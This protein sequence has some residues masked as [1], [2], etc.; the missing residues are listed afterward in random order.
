MACLQCC[1]CSKHKIASLITITG[2]GVGVG[3]TV[4]VIVE[5]VNVSVTVAVSVSV[6]V[7]VEVVVRVGVAV[8]VQVGLGLGVPFK[9]V[10]P[11]NAQFF[12]GSIDRRMVT[13]FGS[14]SKTESVSLSLF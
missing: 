9:I 14:D 8:G 1:P 11:S 13:E 3:G 12:L 5:G 7:I 10:S 2:K 6:G 4:V